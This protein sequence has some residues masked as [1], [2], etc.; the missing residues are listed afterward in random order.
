[1]VLAPCTV[2]TNHETAVRVW[3]SNLSKKALKSQV[4]VAA[5]HSYF[6]RFVGSTKRD[7]KFGSPDTAVDDLCEFD[8]WLK[9][10][11]LAEKKV[12]SPNPT[13]PAFSP[14]PATPAE[15][16]VPKKPPPSKV[17]HDKIIH[18]SPDEQAP[19]KDWW[20]KY[21]KSQSGSTPGPTPESKKRSPLE[22]TGWVLF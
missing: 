12:V 2:L 22:E 19:Y 10:L 8:V 6:K 7:H 18:L 4:N 9:K 21:G 20:G 15:V 5:N 11:A 1:M 13:K 16:A 17:D 14:L 3:L